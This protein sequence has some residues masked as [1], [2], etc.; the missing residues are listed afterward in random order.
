MDYRLS[1][2]PPGEVLVLRQNHNLKTRKS[3]PLWKRGS[4][5]AQ[6]FVVRALYYLRNQGFRVWS[7]VGIGFLG[8]RVAQT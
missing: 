5:E 2:V 6:L 3:N 1:A 8:M 7:T 4:R